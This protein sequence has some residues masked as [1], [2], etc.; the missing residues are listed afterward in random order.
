[1]NSFV[2]NNSHL[3]T[4]IIVILLLAIIVSAQVLY[5][6]SSSMFGKESFRFTIKHRSIIDPKIVKHLAFGFDNVLADY[7]WIS[8][9]QDFTGWDH[10]EDFYLNY[11]KNIS[12]LDPEFSYP[13]LFAILTA[14][15]EKDK[16]SLD[17][18]AEIA[19]LGMAT[20]PNNW[21]I[22]FY[23]GTMYNMFAKD[24]AKA[25][26]YIEIAAK[27]EGVPSVVPLTYSSITAKKLLGKKTARELMSVIRDTT[28]SE[29][30][31]AMA[32]EGIVLSDITVMLENAII[33]YKAKHRTYPKT[34]ENLTAERFVVIP[35][36]ITSRFDII[37]NQ[38]N[39]E[40]SIVGK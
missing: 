16:A 40:V 32:E 11:F 28:K 25:L 37:I 24:E 20:L 8:A 17:K 26:H 36:E 9:V 33:A 30:I 18:V 3:F 13:Y 21:E 23:L 35:K 22:P 1:M 12:V 39:G 31:K 27:T 15:T 14:P 7:Y 5:D 10:K 38:K 29:T 34:I 2:K 19:E 6:H 4:G